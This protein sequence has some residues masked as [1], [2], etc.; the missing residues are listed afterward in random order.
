VSGEKRYNGKVMA[1]DLQMTVVECD[2]MCW[3][4]YGN[5]VWRFIGGGGGRRR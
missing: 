2:I 3:R 1:H 4:W 5:V